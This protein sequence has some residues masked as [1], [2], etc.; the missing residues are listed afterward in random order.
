[1]GA[2][3][4]WAM[5]FI[6]NRAI[7]M[8][9]GSDA[10]QIAYSPEYTAGSFFLPICVVGIAFYLLTITEAVS[11]IAIAS[12]GFTTGVAV[13]G[14]HYLGQ[15]GIANYH[16]VYVWKYIIGASIIAIV[17]STLA[18]GVFFYFKSAW[19]NT[20]WKRMSC[21][22]LLAMA[23]SGMHWVATVGTSYRFRSSLGQQAGL[24]R[25]AT[26]I[27]VLG[28]VRTMVLF[29]HEYW[30]TGI[31]NRMLLCFTSFCFYRTTFSSV[32]CRQGTASR[33]SM[34][35]VGPRWENHGHTR[36]HVTMPENHQYL[37]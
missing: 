3:A 9:D 26:V 17:A 32:V 2:V 33:T 25:R 14:M 28:L 30:L 5:H 31:G 37:R 12:G 23:V 7:T 29:G 1:M 6:G 21:A 24:S 15:G 8:G 27:I 19:T 22:F 4:I 36:W 34:C 11:P 18:L 13:C 35:N 20:W 10:L 16:T